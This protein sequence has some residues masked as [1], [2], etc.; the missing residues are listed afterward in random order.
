MKVKAAIS[1]LPDGTLVI[2]DD[3]GKALN[4]VPTLAL[5]TIGDGGYLQ[6]QNRDD[7]V[8]Y[9][10]GSVAYVDK[11]GNWQV[12]N[13]TGKPVPTTA[14]FKAK[15][16]KPW[17]QLTSYIGGYQSVPE[18]PEAYTTDAHLHRPR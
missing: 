13:A 11:D 9:E 3:Q 15:W 10:P 5:V 6:W 14:E 17:R 12:L 1:T 4:D 7:E 16:A 8:A 2:T 18:L